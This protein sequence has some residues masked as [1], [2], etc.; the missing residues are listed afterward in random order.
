MKNAVLLLLLLPFFGF[1]QT[2]LVSWNSL[3]PAT[4][5]NAHLTTEALASNEISVENNSWSGFRIGNLHN[6]SG[7]GI[8][9]QKY[10]QFKITPATGYNA[11]LSAFNFIYSSPSNDGTGPTKVQVRYSTSPSFPNNG[12]LLGSEQTLVLNQNATYSQNF[13][14]NYSVPAATSLYIR[15]YAYGAPNIYYTDFYIRNT[16][17]SA[18]TNG[19]SITGT[20]TSAASAVM[21]AVNDSFNANLNASTVLN[22]LGND[23]AAGSVTSITATN[24]AHGT[25]IVN[26]DKTITYTPAANYAGQD[27]FTYTITNGTNPIST[28]TVSLNVQAMAPTAAL[29][30]TYLV[31][32]NGHFATITAAV[33]SL[34][35]YGISGPV[36]FL[37]KNATYGANESFPLTI[38]T[39]AN[40][41]A[42]NIVTF[43]PYTGVSPVITAA[44]I[45]GY[46]GIPA[47]FYINGADYITFDGSNTATGTSRN[48]TLDNQD[49]IDYIERSVFWV[50]SNGTNG[51]T[52][53]TVKN[54]NIKQS[55]RNQGGKFSVG[56]YSGNNGT[57][58]N[59]TML[60][61]AATANNSSLTITNNDFTN[62]KQGVYV[63]G[64]SVITS[65]VLI[66][67]N[68]LGATTN[69][70]T[71]IAPAT[72]INVSSF[73]YNDNL[74]NN[75]YRTTDDGNLVSAGIYVAGASKN[76]SILRNT[77]KDLTKTTTNNQ[78]FGG[79][80]LASTDFNANIIVANNFILNVTGSGNGGGYLNGYGIIADNGGGYKIYNN[81][82][83]LNTNQPNGGFSAPFYVNTPARNLDV[84]NNIFANNQTNIA[85]RRT[86][87]VVNNTLSNINTVFTNLDNNDYFSNDR[88]AYIANVN[89]A[90]QIDWAGNGIQGDY[91][92]N[93]DYLYT[94]ERWKSL[95]TKDAHSV[96]VNPTFI[97]NSDLHINANGNNGGI[98]DGGVAVPGIT[99]DIDNQL[100]NVTTPDMGADEFGPSNTMPVAGDPTGLYCDSA[101]TWNGTTWSNGAPNASKDVIFNGNFTQNGGTFYACSIYVLDGSSV[102]FTND[103]NTIVTHA[104]NVA[105]SGSLTFESSS[106]LI[107]LTD[108]VNSGTTTVKRNS[109]KLKKLDYTMWSAPVLDKRATGYQTLQSFSPATVATRFYEYSTVNNYYQTLPA[110]TTKFTLGKGILIRM[111][112]TDPATGYNEG[113][114]RL[115]YN[116]SF[117]GTPNNGTLSVPVALTGSGYNAIGNPYPSPISV[118]AF[119]NENLDVIDGTVWIWRKTNDRTVSSY[120]TI[121]LTGYV[122]NIARGGSNNDGN[123]LIADPYAIDPNGSLNTAQGFIVKAKVAGNVTYKN[124]MRLQTNSHSFFRT[125]A[126]TTT[127]RLWINATNETGEFS[128]SLV[129]YN[130]DTTLGYDNGYDGKALINGNL[131]LYTIAE[132]ANDT[133][134][135][136]IQSR[137]AFATTDRVKMGYQTEV[138]GTFT[139][140]LDHTDGRFAE[141]QEIYVIDNVTGITHNLTDA[142]FTFT[143]EVG[144]FN[145]RF[146]VAYAPSGALGT[147]TPVLQTKEIM[148]YKSGKQVKVEAPADIN[149]VTVYDMLGKTIFQKSN[150]DGL[151]FATTD[152]NITAQVVIVQITL[153]NQQ[154]IS[155]K[156]IMN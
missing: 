60:I 41:S 67:K 64:G 100:R 45:N 39:I 95:T 149:T 117:T 80:V 6:G 31:G 59:N 136:T 53:I 71:I 90:T 120:S 81:T 108:D 154:V 79:I 40:A 142:A 16:G 51:A 24:P 62:V 128:Q 102:S 139:L 9:Y 8:N 27:S 115:V 12:T 30:G 20:V 66:N 85:T 148:V 147:E 96:N 122:A 69:A 17:F 129:A 114:A 116:G 110:E 112:N 106:N 14:A 123:D 19:P 32:A 91:N 74:V 7:S 58:E 5:T 121:N 132:T 13:P 3:Q 93:A 133:L 29:N 94:L 99:R 34:N 144:T 28:A 137:G 10:L 42:T 119:I 73:E 35:T 86:A 104:V 37:L 130:E 78:I 36:T 11:N 150:I 103:S 126:Q 105:A 113:T 135:L 72:L 55:V 76:G 23:T 131:N 146:T 77:L 38:N 124:T 52:H 125:A 98:A 87:I 111:P 26:A 143:S 127:D 75:L 15:V 44:N 101:T 49:A 56:I 33:N 107:Q 152:L 118:K 68:D 43:K 4:S 70:E 84:R 50:A 47:V 82:V 21:A 54:C 1:S 140:S 156:I 88:I 153:D 155:K 18:G 46:T 48:L 92:D 134:N 109:S 2:N 141:G 89:A 145:E 61:T 151:S 97:S 65:G 138:A 63:N 83:S 25:L 22:V 57:G